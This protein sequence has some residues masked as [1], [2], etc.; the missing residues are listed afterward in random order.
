M[1]IDL[2]RIPSNFD[3][4]DMMRMGLVPEHLVNFVMKLED[5][6]ILARKV[7]ERLERDN[8]IINEQLGFA[9]K[10]ISSVV[11]EAKSATKCK[12]L[13]KFIVLE[14]ENSYLEL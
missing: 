2:D 8:D 5:E 6:L 10:Y 12:D 13:V 3:L 4:D 7:V 9:R 11:D 1:T 14:L